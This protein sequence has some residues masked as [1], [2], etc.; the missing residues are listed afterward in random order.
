MGDVKPT[1]RAGTEVSPIGIVAFVAFL[2]VGGMLVFGF[3]FMLVPAARAQAQAPCRPLDPVPLSLH[4]P[5]AALETL[6]GEAVD[7]ADYAGKFLVVNF[8]ATYCE[9]CTRE[10]PDLDKLARRLEGRDDIVVLAISIDP[11]KPDIAPY[12][13]R[14]TLLDSPVQVL[15]DASNE[16][17]K[18]FGGG[19]PGSEKIPNTFFVD[20]G[21]VIRH[22]YIDTRPWGRPEAHRCVE[23]EAGA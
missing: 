18:E 10:W 5:E 3:A 12:L 22:A 7:L 1:S 6:D 15:W 13:E 9:P 4:L 19:L 8:W 20:R 2:L 16:L 17:P 11:K 21:G 23:H 14:M